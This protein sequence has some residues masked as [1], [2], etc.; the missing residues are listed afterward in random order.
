M[1]VAICP[2]TTSAAAKPELLKMG[3]TAHERAEAG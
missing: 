2:T 1:T 3:W